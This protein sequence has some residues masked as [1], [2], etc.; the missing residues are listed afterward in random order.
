MSCGLHHFSQ[1]HDLCGLHVTGSTEKASQVAAA[2]PNMFFKK[3][4]LQLKDGDDIRRERRGRSQ[5]LQLLSCGVL[6]TNKIL[7]VELC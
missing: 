6:Y 2:S 3:Q 4:R 5:Q 7:V 1:A